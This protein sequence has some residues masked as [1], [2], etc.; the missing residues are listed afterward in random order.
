MFDWCLRGQHT[1]C[2]KSYRRF[3]FEKKRVGKKVQEVMEFGDTVTCDC[4]C[5]KKGK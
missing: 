5:H 3:W 2:H 1:A 4:K